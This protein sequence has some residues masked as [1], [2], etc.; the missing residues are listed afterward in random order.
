[1][2]RTGYPAE[3]RRKVLDLVAAGQPVTRITAELDI[4][5]PT[6]YT[7]ARQDRIGQGLEPDLRAG[8]KIE[9]A[10]ARRWVHQLETEL[11][12]SRQ[13]MELTREAVPPEFRYAAVTTMAAEGIPVDVACRMPDVST[14]GYYASLNRPLSPRQIRHV[15]LTETIRRTH[16]GSR[17]TYGNRR[18]RAELVPGRGLSIGRHPVELLMHRAGLAGAAG[19]PRNKRYRPDTVSAELVDQ[20][21]AR[22]SLEQ[23]WITDITKH[24]MR[25]GEVYCAV[26]LDVFSR[27]VVGWSIDYS[28]TAL[29]TRNALSMAILQLRPACGY[30][31][32]LRPWGAVRLLGLHPACQGIRIGPFDGI[33]RRL[34][35]QRP[36]GIL[37]S[38][39]QIELLD[40][41]RWKTRIELA[42]AIFDYLDIWHNRLRRYSA[43]GCISPVEYEMKHTTVA[44]KSKNATP[45][46][47]RHAKESDHWG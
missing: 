20:K 17:D 22:E 18:V 40:R 8:E 30:G 33:D 47:Q 6:I 35:R 32:P 29:L 3:F 44:W 15:P 45:R 38:R 19:R 31:D 39:M 26:V 46:N 4:S 14:S 28:S 34:L 27:S 36:H 11:A 1:M 24:H 10:E 37:W 23:L 43:L 7:R 41:H 12:A 16:A 42:N 9:L 21:F 5:D 2:G 13:T 25:E